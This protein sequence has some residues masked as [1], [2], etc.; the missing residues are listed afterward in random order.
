[1]ASRIDIDLLTI[2]QAADM[3]ARHQALAYNYIDLD[4]HPDDFE[5]RWEASSR[6]AEGAIIRF[7]RD[8][9]VDV[10]PVKSLTRVRLINPADRF[11]SY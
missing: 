1:M 5:R 10:L 7:M 9:G 4:L 11:I 3:M 2:A 8:R 6:L